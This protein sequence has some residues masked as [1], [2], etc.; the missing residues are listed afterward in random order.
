MISVLQNQVVLLSAKINTTDNQ[1]KRIHSA[2]AGGGSN[3][4]TQP[5]KTG[6]SGYD[7]PVGAHLASAGGSNDP[8]H[9]RSV[10]VIMYNPKGSRTALTGDDNVIGCQLITPALF[11]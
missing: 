10:R 5:M 7:L 11:E 9:T 3:S 1:S 6:D 2:T 8:H 4:S